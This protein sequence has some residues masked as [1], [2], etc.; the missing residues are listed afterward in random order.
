MI[1]MGAQ[2]FFLHCYAMERTVEE[3][4]NTKPRDLEQLLGEHSDIFQKP[5]H[6][7]LPPHSRDDIIDLMPRSSL[8]GLGIVGRNSYKIMPKYGE[9]HKGEEEGSTTKEAT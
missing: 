2:A 6:G 4:Q 9:E 8:L 5:P 3:I 1:K 7:V